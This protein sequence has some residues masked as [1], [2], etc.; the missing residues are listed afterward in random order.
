MNTLQSK[1]D[2]M[3]WNAYEKSIFGLTTAGIDAFSS[4]AKGMKI[5]QVSIWTDLEARVSAIN[6]ETAAHAREYAE[7]Y[8]QRLKDD[9]MYAKAD[10]ILTAGRSSNP[11]N[12]L[13]RDAAECYHPELEPLR[14]HLGSRTRFTCADAYLSERLKAVRTAILESGLLRDVPHEDP[15]WFGISSEESWYDHEE[16]THI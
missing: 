14:K 11:A 3:D 8:A 4:A 6:F 7:A 10:E 15:V 5:F 13:Y 2:A 12:F 16:A 1:L 9:K